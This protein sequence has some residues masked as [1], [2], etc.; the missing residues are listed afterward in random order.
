MLIVIGLLAALA[1]GL[2]GV[3]ALR[4]KGAIGLLQGFGGGAVVGVALLDLLPEGFSLSG[5]AHPAFALCTAVAAGFAAY[6]LADQLVA[7]SQ[8]TGSLRGHVGPATLTAHSLMDGL[9]GGLAFQ[10][11][12]TAGWILAIAVL[13]HELVDG[14]NT[15]TVSL[16]GGAS[17][18]G[19]T[20]WLA[21]DALAPLVG[22]GLSGLIAVP[23]ATLGLLLAVFAG[24]FAYIG[25]SELV[26]QARQRRPH[27][28]TT[29][30]TLLGM[31]AIYLAVRLA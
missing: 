25:A 9:G 11:S 30:A 23:S 21:A 14:A 26:P 17:R 20:A 1:T 4:L 6:L 27:L 16:S 31:A 7:A 2:G 22:V 13:A 10:V 24:F 18:P 5:K 19:A 3:L 29:L 28:T 12:P 8:R 15:V